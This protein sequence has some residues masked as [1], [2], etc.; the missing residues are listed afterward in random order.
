MYRTICATLLIP[1]L[2]AAQSASTPDAW[3]AVERIAA[4][5]R[6]QIQLHDYSAMSGR[7]DHATADAVYVLHGGKTTEVRRDNVRKVYRRK[8]GHGSMWA[9]IGAVAGAGAL[10]GGFGPRIESGPSKAYGA[11]VAGTVALGAIIGAGVGYG[12]GHGR[13]ELIYR[14]PK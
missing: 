13:L 9:A 7:L 6:V 10:G 2:A 1:F 3:E 4:G 8:P 5:E 12:L 11:A 14:A